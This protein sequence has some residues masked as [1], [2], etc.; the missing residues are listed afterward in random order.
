[1]AAKI[2][3]LCDQTW[4]RYSSAET[5]DQSRDILSDFYRFKLG[6]K[7]LGATTQ[8]RS[9]YPFRFVMTAF[10][11]ILLL[12]MVYQ[13]FVCWR[14]NNFY[15]YVPNKFPKYYF[16]AYTKRHMVL[17]YGLW[18]KRCLLFSLNFQ[19]GAFFCSN[20][21]S[22]NYSALRRYGVSSSSLTS[23]LC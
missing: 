11:D 13:L 19:D 2:S 20:L 23:A 6:L 15:I 22:Y 5:E 16:S 10:L 14:V 3:Q 21:H 1:M 18:S 9:V 8:K 12:D 17:H 4:Q 7:G